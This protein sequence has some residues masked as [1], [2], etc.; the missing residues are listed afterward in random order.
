MDCDQG[1]ARVESEHNTVESGPTVTI[2][3]STRHIGHLYYRIAVYLETKTNC[4]RQENCKISHSV[5]VTFLFGNYC[6]S[7]SLNTPPP[8]QLENALTLCH[9][10][11][12]LQT[13]PPRSQS[14][15]PLLRLQTFTPAPT[16][17]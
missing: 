8:P 6:S 14:N 12:P 11:Y 9:V 4:G 15:A 1:H 3:V 5:R 2:G 17:R 7:S 16:I 13:L 10:T